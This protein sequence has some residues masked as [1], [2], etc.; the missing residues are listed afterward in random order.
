M[1]ITGKQLRESITNRSA[2]Y[3]EMF[4]RTSTWKCVKTG[5]V[6]L[7]N[8]DTYALSFQDSDHIQINNRLLKD[9]QWHKKADRDSYFDMIDKYTKKGYVITYDVKRL[10]DGN[11]YLPLLIAPDGKKLTSPDSPYP[12]YFDEL[13]FI[14]RYELD[15]IKL[16]EQCEG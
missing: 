15:L 16:Y 13:S 12:Q 2:P 4:P 7:D 14:F 11:Q 9:K 5:W 3:Q 6:D 1:I 10:P 8:N